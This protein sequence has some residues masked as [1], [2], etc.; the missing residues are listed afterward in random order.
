MTI[1]SG[2]QQPH[3]S[4]YEACWREYD[5]R[6]SGHDFSKLVGLYLQFG[7]LFSTPEFFVI[8][9]PILSTADAELIRNPAHV[10]E[11][12]DTWHLAA[13]WGDAHKLWSIFPFPLPNLSWY[14][15]K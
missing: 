10:F 8:G 9:R 15:L 5:Q 3:M 13:F 7:Y 1:D 11:N 12:P 6:T 2:G 4:P 14:K